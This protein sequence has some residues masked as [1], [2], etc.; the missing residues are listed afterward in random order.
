MYR[1]SKDWS[2]SAGGVEE[3]V[4]LLHCATVQVICLL[5]L[6]VSVGVFMFTFSLLMAL[7][8]FFWWGVGGKVS[9]P[10]STMPVM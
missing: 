8:V 6:V 3:E 10:S 5:V 7:L 9:S 1:E 4:L 2:L